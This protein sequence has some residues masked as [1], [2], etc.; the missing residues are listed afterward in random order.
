M[1][2]FK[3]DDDFADHPR[4]LTLSDAAIVAWFRSLAYASR[5][6]TDGFIPEGAISRLHGDPRAVSELVDAGRL[7]AVEGGWQIKNYLKYQRSREQIER[8]RDRDRKRKGKPA[9]NPAGNPAGIPR[10]ES[11][12][13]TDISRSSLIE[14]KEGHP[15]DSVDD[16]E[17]FW[18]EVW[19]TFAQKQ[20]SRPNVSNRAAFKRKVLKSCASE[21]GERAR[22]LIAKWELTAYQLGSVLAGEESILVS[23]PRRVA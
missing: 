22:E 3:V 12:S 6:L 2:W 20:S 23:A 21:H 7:L 15:Q 14:T 11:E 10:P 18:S 9:G 17:G 5:Y 16:D 8:E 4:F 19:E 13:E 1:T